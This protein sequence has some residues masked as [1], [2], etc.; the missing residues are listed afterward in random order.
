MYVYISL[1]AVYQPVAP[2]QAVSAVMASTF[3]LTRSEN[4]IF[5]KVGAVRIILTMLKNVG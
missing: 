1:L 2:F 5:T 4:M 3:T